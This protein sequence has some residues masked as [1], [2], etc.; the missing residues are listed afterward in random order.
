MIPPQLLPCGK[1][2]T[3]GIH[4]CTG[5]KIEWTPEDVERLKKVMEEIFNKLKEQ[6]ANHP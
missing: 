2:G 1:C 5:V 3:T 4:A 6:D